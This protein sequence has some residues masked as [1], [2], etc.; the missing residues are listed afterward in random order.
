MTTIDIDELSLVLSTTEVVYAAIQSSSGPHVT[1]ELFTVADGKILCLTSAV[2]LKARRARATPLLAMCAWSDAG[3]VSL[4][5]TVEVVDPTSPRSLLE[6]P[7]TSLKLPLGVARFMLDNAAEMAGAALDAAAGRLG[8]PLPPHRVALAVTPVAATMISDGEI[9]LSSGW[10]P[11]ER[12][13]SGVAEPEGGEGFDLG[14]LP[15]PL[16]SLAKNGRAAVGWMG[17]NGSPLALPAVWRTESTEARVPW[18]LFEACRAVDEGPGCV[19]FDTWT[20]FGPSGKQGVM[21]RGAATVRRSGDDAA[22]SFQLD[23]ASYWDG[24]ETGTV[25]AGSA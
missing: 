14:L 13:I 25:D 7:A 22:I 2:T 9:V 12:P 10:E 18:A 5:G 1:P 16:A 23:R 20:G 6:A 24:V 21:L 4:V 19:T 8:R 3:L 11:A 15:G 17:Q